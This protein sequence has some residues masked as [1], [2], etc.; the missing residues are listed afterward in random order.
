[1]GTRRLAAVAVVD[2]VGYSAMMSEDEDG[3]LAAWQDHRAAVDPLWPARGGRIVKGTGDGPL[4]E[5]ASA[6]EAVRAAVEVQQLMKP[7]QWRSARVGAD[8]AAHRCPRG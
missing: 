1:M 4:V 8:A 6:V 2:V 3:T 5:V 7:S